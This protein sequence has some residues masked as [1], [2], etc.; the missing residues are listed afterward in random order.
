MNVIVANKYRD[1]LMDLDIDVIKSVEGVYDASEISS[2]FQNFFF[3]WMILDITSINNY[4]D[5][6]NLQELSVGLD[7]GKIILVLDDSEESSSP[8]YLSKLISLGIYNFTRNKEGIKYLIQH[9][10]S[11]KDVANLHELNNENKFEKPEKKQDKIEKPKRKKKEKKEPEDK[12]EEPIIEEPIVDEKIEEPIEEPVKSHFIQIEEETPLEE[13]TNQHDL[14]ENNINTDKIIGFRN[15][16]EHAGSTSL[17][18]MLKEQLK[19]KFNIIALEV[20][21]VDFSFYK[22]PSL[23]STSK[24][25]LSKEILKRQEAEIVLVDLNDYDDSE[26]CTDVI[27]LIEPST[28]KLNK[29]MLKNK[30][31]F[32]ELEGKKIVLNRST[33]EEKEVQ[34]FEYEA[35]TKIFANIPCIDDRKLPNDKIKELANKLG[36]IRE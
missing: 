32:K 29:L 1:M 35:R 15:V 31:I 4:K 11:Y 3:Q 19:D 25:E 17:I 6:S 8:E 13:S 28:I 27:Y 18:Y 12:I 9:P 26:I 24:T 5:I 21:K 10:N 34:E 33:I 2:M 20:D 23:I 16:T 22:D 7:V 36:F 14:M 30:D